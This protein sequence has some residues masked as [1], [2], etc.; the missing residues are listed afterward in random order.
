MPSVEKPPKAVRVESRAM[1]ALAHRL[2]R[3]L[4]HCRLKYARRASGPFGGPAHGSQGEG[5]LIRGR[6][7][8]LLASFKHGMGEFQRRI[9][10]KPLHRSSNP[11]TRPAGSGEYGAG[12][13]V[14]VLDSHSPLMRT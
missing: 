12:D 2:H 7:S 1:A 11:D 10:S 3:V 9:F 13:S 8:G 14:W 6:L 5:K 4:E